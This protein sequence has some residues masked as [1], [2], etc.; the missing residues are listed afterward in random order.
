MHWQRDSWRQSSYYH[1]KPGNVRQLR[2]ILGVRH[3][4]RNNNRT[5]LLHPNS[6]RKIHPRISRCR[7]TA[8]TVLHSWAGGI[9]PCLQPP[10]AN[11]Y[12]NEVPRYLCWV[13]IYWANVLR[14]GIS[15]VSYRARI[16]MITVHYCSSIT[17]AGPSHE[18]RRLD[19][20]SCWSTVMPLASTATITPTPGKVLLLV[21]VAG[22]EW[23]VAVCVC[24][25][26]CAG[27][28]NI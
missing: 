10:S 19:V 18:D 4:N 16:A 6:V 5:A 12:T 26:V 27:G 23:R 14:Y 8:W 1:E 24:V 7:R 28:G 17:C 21:M 9:V 13:I 25:C 11:R 2:S 20:F 22:G 3:R 15:I